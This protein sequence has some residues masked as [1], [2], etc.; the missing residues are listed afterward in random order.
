MDKWIAGEKYVH[1]VHPQAGTT[2]LVYYNL[3]I[4]SLFTMDMALR[5]VEQAYIE[6]SNGKGAVWPMV[7]HEFKHGCA[8]P[9]NG[10]DT[11][12]RLFSSFALV[13]PY[14]PRFHF[15]QCLVYLHYRL[16]LGPPICD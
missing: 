7:F 6:K 1:Y 9:V 11:L 3:D 5:A 10:V 13:I 8:H 4:E 15:R 16:E 14:R 2:A 12:P